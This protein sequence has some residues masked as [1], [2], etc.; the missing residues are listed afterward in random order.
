LT[1]FLSFSEKRLWAAISLLLLLLSIVG[2]AILAILMFG[3]TIE[4]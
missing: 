3:G 1:I 4:L 2:T